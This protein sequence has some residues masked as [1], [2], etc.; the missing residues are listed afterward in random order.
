MNL[1]CVLVS[2]L[3][4]AASFNGA[5]QPVAPAE[6]PEYDHVIYSAPR[7][8]WRG[9]IVVENLPIEPQRGAQQSMKPQQSPLGTV[10]Y[11]V[12][13]PDTTKAGPWTTVVEVFGNKR[14]PI[15]LLIRLTDHLSGGVR[16]RWLNEQLLWLQMWRGRIVSTDTIL[17]VETGRFVYARDAN[18]NSLIVPCS[19]KVGVQKEALP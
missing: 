1:R 15:H 13:E 19:A 10:S 4:A 3:F 6:C 9:S 18:Y 14:R 7:K 5:Q 17:N 8:D 11:I 12:R 16:T 2:W